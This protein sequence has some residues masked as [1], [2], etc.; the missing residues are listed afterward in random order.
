MTKRVL[1]AALCVLAGLSARATPRHRVASRPEL[2]PA[3]ASMP[4]AFEVNQGQTST[5]AAFVA[6]AAGQTIF[7][8]QDGTVLR[9][10]RAKTTRD[11]ISGR[12]RT[13][14][15]LKMTFM[16][17]SPRTHVSGEDPLPGT[18]NY[19]T[20]NDPV[21]W[22]RNVPTFGK[23]RYR[24][25]YPGIDAVYY[26]NQSRLEY[27]LIVQ[28]HAD[29]GQIVLGF[30]GARDL[31]ID[32]DGDLLLSTAVG[33]L[34]HHKPF[35]YQADGA[36]RRRRIAGKY[37]LKESDR[38]GFE[39][40]KYDRSRPLIIDP[41]LFYSTFVGGGGNDAGWDIAVDGAGNA[42]VIGSTS[43]IEFP[44]TSGSYST[45]YAGGSD[46]FVLKLNS[47]GS[48]LFYSTYLGG[49]AADVG[50]AVAIDLSG[51]VYVTGNTMSSDFPVTPGA[52]DGTL[53]GPFDAWVAKLDA[54]GSTLLYSTYLGGSDADFGGEDITVDAVGD[55]YVTGETR[56]PDFPTTPGAYQMALHGFQDA[57][58]TKLNASG[59]A[60]IYS[61]FLG[62]NDTYGGPEDGFGITVD[63]AGNAYVAG[64]TGSIDF[65]TTAL[66]YDTTYNGGILDAFAAK[67][68]PSGSTLLYS[69]Y[70]GGSDND[71]AY[72]IPVDA[73]GNAYLAGFTRSTDFPV[74]A[75]AFQTANAGDFD[76]FAVKLDALGRSLAY[77]TYLGG[78]G[79]DEAWGLT[80]DGSGD[81]YVTGFTR[82]T[83]FPVSANAFQ[84][85]YGGG[86]SD[87]FVTKLN[88]AGSG[89]VY[90]SYLGGT[91]DD[92][93]LGIALDA[94]PSP[95]AYVTGQTGSIDF[96]VTSGAFQPVYAGGSNDAFVTKIL[97]LVL[98]PP[99]TV[100]KVT[101]GGSIARVR[102]LG[103]FGFI[104]QREAADASI[105]G[106]LQ[107]VRHDTHE[108]I[109][110]TSFTSFV[111]AGTA[112]TFS[113][114]CT[115]NGVPCT[116]SVTAEDDGEPGKDDTFTIT[117][118]VGPP[119][120][121]TL[122]SGNIKIHD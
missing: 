20:S 87:A 110:S 100:G 105:T 41:V 119:E 25:L 103:T 106:S 88:S 33:T 3:L 102:G 76:A 49:T 42:Y 29:I 44:A 114:A 104:V 112:A 101:G 28:P 5:E 58:V 84:T 22:R 65:P 118:N 26:G 98:P 75:G 55:A 78:S 107:Y 90:S 50:L 45:T 77:A 56:S 120:G 121:G 64:R 14:A 96:P 93:G 17:A 116:F 4:L 39:I 11:R 1:A 122:R 72:E 18:A 37:V 43:S 36:G 12:D 79:D 40:G 52:H 32:S 47:T 109:R 73:A 23:V 115:V 53:D 70:I 62:G 69:T 15:V 80:V 68:D 74:S 2:V 89:V 71:Q 51:N 19:F 59:T 8:T 30:D 61:T 13:E 7:L 111:I 108:A 54:S 34:T 57:T 94:L 38:V 9:L 82:S 6:R 63:A 67:V 97:D 86:P 66:A 85:A 92:W 113:G 48:G 24:N 91:G 46:T 83:N 10:A 35:I 16:G 31:Q 95:N 21:R 60:L 117:I 27:D 99:V 81:A